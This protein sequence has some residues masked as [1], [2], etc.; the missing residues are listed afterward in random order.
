MRTKLAAFMLMVGAASGQVLMTPTNVRDT[1]QSGPAYTLSGVA[2]AY[3]ITY[4]VES[5]AGVPLSLDDGSA[6]RLY[7]WGADGHLVSSNSPS[8][9]PLAPLSD[10][11]VKFS[12]ANIS[13]GEYRL[14]GVATPASGDTNENWNFTHHMLTVTNPPSA[15]GGGSM[16]VVISNQHMAS[17]RSDGSP[18]GRVPVSRSDGGVDLLPWAAG[19]GDGNVVATNTGTEGQVLKSSGNGNTGYWGNAASGG[20]ESNV[21]RHIASYTYTGGETSV[22]FD[23]EPYCRVDL[24]MDGQFSPTNTAGV[25]PVLGVQINGH[26]WVYR[27]DMKYDTYADA[28]PN[29]VYSYSSWYPG[30]SNLFVLGEVSMRNANVTYTRGMTAARWSFMSS[31][32]GIHMEGR[33]HMSYGLD[34]AGDY[35]FDSFGSLQT[36]DYVNNNAITQLVVICMNLT[37]GQYLVSSQSNATFRLRGVRCD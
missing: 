2:G 20:G 5:T 26:P 13:A 12:F 8:G 36:N 37:N 24:D 10:G 22:T 32:R 14:Q 11:K 28:H 6:L 34:F 4:T 31:A 18:T 21:Y 35:T 29:T 30:S 3:R 25:F 16:T 1:V 9:Q 19:G 23:F 17:L 33:G 7:V 27:T 15:G